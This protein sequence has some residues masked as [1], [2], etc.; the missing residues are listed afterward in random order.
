MTALPLS[1]SDEFVNM[2]A[3]RVADV[4]LERLET[5][6]P[7]SAPSPWLDAAGVAEYASMSIEGIRSA[8]KR[9]QLKSHR[10]TTGR[11][12]YLRDDVDAFLRGEE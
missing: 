11:V 9:G 2:L 4:V 10:S 3:V 6:S 8:T 7:S 12:R 1:V 5:R